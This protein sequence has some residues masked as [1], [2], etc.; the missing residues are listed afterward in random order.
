M[1]KKQ[2]MELNAIS[3]LHLILQSEECAFTTEIATDDGDTT[4]QCIPLEQIENIKIQ[5]DLLERYM[6]AY[7]KA[8]NNGTETPQWHEIKANPKAYKLNRE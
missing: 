7:N 3:N 5:L 2:L 1:A 8:I 6:V 4:C